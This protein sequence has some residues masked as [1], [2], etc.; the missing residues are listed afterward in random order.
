MT[1]LFIRFYLGVLVVLFLAWYIHG[2]VSK[3]KSQADLARVIKA[4][5]AGGARVVADELSAASSPEG[6]EEVLGQIRD[7]FD[8]KVTICEFADLEDAT[9]RRLR[10]GADTAYDAGTVVAKLADE[11]FV[12]LGTFPRYNRQEIEAALAGWMRLTRDRVGGTPPEYRVEELQKL[13]KK[14]EQPIAIVPLRVLPDQASAVADS[15]HEIAFYSKDGANYYSAIKLDDQDAIRFGPFQ[16]FDNITQKAATTT[17]GL[18]LLPVAIAI[19]LLLR[20]VAFQLRQLENA[21]EAIAGGDLSARVDVRHMRSA[22]PLANSFN[23]MAGRTETLVR[24]QRELLQAVS[25]ELRTPLA[26]MRF[27]IDLIETSKS[28]Q[29]RRDKLASLDAATEELDGLVGELLSYVRL[30]T[31][32]PELQPEEISLCETIRTLVP[33]YS[34]LYPNIDFRF[35]E[36]ETSVFADRNGFQRA[37]GNLVSNAGRHA[38]SVVKVT[39]AQNGEATTIDVDDD[40]PGIPN[41]ERQRVFEPFVRLENAEGKNGAGLGLAL[42]QRIVSQNGGSVEVLSSPLG[43]CRIRTTWPQM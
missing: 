37:I 9:Q 29:E 34:A 25:H 39:A 14:F 19:A 15:D 16:R 27:A 20:P 7:R 30:E 2:S 41:S 35:D 4:A 22:K 13:Q 43:G 31:A 32:E 23:H 26:R 11:R 5:H 33:K 36:V 21:A 18:V 17:L 40:G 24:T 1:R 10:S 6:F 28:D 42:V 8:Y 12:R 38:E 3:S